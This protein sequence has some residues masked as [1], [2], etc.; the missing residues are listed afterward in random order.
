MKID[1]LEISSPVFMAPLAGITDSVF[2]RLVVGH[3]AGMVYTELVSAEGLV[4]GGEKT[5]HLMD[6]TEGERPIGVQIFGSRPEAMGQAAQI[7]SRRR[8]DLIDLNFGCPSKK[9]V[10]KNGGAALLRDL[11]LMEKILRAVVTAADLPVTVKI[12]SGWDQDSIVAVEV[13]AMCQAWGVAAITV[14]PRTRQQGFSGQADWEIIRQVKESVDIPVIGNGDVRTPED[15]MRMFKETGCDAIMIGR[16]ALGNPW[17]FRQIAIRVQGGPSEAGPSLD[18][19]I[20]L[21]MEHARQM[22][23]HKGE[24]AG[25]R[26]MRKHYGWYTKGFPGGARLRSALVT[27][28]HLEDVEAAFGKYR[29]EQAKDVKVPSVH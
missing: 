9:V 6:F 8:P 26:E 13:A 5:F 1:S 19:K 22:I 27:L 28:E 29:D 21:S 18:E 23:A 14:H 24:Y 4:H 15:G 3:G 10:A 17:L 12:R 20:N 7:A 25:I 11:P 2:R 16:G